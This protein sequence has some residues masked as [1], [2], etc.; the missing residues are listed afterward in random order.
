M[1]IKLIRRQAQ[2]GGRMYKARQQRTIHR[3]KPSMLAEVDSSHVSR[4]FLFKNYNNL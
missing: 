1:F 3:D 2:C 4:Y